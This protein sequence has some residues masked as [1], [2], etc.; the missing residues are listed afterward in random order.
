MAF[1]KISR[2]L[3]ELNENIKAFS[4]SNAEYYKLE[5][6]K[7]AMKGA[8]ALVKGLIVGT[9]ALFA[10]VILSVAVA[11]AIS[12]ALGE[13]SSGFF[14]V[15]GFYIL[16]IILFLLFAEKPL[17]KLMLRKISRSFFN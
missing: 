2:S 7:Q 12:E 15:G 3:N 9:F 8:T 5:F 16:L 10:L 11:I 6:F 17:N 4:Q 13:P 14:I 1:D